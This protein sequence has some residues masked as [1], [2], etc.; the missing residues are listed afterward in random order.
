LGF[1]IFRRVHFV[2]RISLRDCRWPAPKKRLFVFRFFGVGR[3]HSFS[4]LEKGWDFLFSEEFILLS[5][6]GYVTVG[7]QRQKGA[8]FVFRFFGVGRSHYFWGLERGWDFLF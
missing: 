3:S 7:G 4:D 1:F 6:L 5:G 8:F 2:I